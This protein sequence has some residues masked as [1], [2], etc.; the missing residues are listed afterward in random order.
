MYGEAFSRDQSARFHS[1]FQ[2][3]SNKKHTR[4]WATT[5]TRE[6]RRLI[7]D[8]L[9]RKLSTQIGAPCSG[10][11]SPVFSPGRQHVHSQISRVD[12]FPENS[13]TGSDLFRTFRTQWKIRKAIMSGIVWSQS[14]CMNCTLPVSHEAIF[15]S[16]SGKFPNFP[17]ALT[18]ARGEL[19][20]F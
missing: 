11:F 14:C 15:R 12:S 16:V 9:A 10:C 7:K 19:F 4:A 6:N 13:G 3:F 17:S 8:T 2:P 20:R 18:L 5:G 1:T